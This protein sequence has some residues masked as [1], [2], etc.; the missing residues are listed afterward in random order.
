M[1]VWAILLVLALSGCATTYGS[2][3]CSMGRMTAAQLDE[4]AL[5]DGCQP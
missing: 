2:N 1:K 5:V 4:G 3:P